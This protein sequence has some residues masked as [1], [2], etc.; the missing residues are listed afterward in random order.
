MIEEIRRQIEASIETK[1]SLPV[2]Q[3]A[4]AVEVVATALQAGKKLLICGNGGSAADA[5]HLAAEL[6]GRYLRERPALPAIA[7]ST[8]S[9]TVTAIGNDYGYDVVF[10]RQ[11]DAF[12]QAGDVVLGIST[13]GNSE[14]V[15]RALVRARERG[16][17]T[18][19]LTG[20]DG[21]KMAALC[22]VHLNVPSNETPRI[23]ESHIL[24]GHILCDLVEQRLMPE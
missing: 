13:S 7:L 12:G 3:L 14:N 18:L 5:Q 15:N 17:A 21:G 19:G 8:N 24:L 22:D 9:S 2:E 16:L 11:I 1:R 4:R 10:E 6:V 20:R 23:Q